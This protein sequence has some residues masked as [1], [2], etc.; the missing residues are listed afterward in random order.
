MKYKI[1][2]ALCQKICEVF[3]GK[4]LDIKQLIFHGLDR[5]NAM[6]GKRLGLQKRLCH[7]APHSKYVNCCNDSLALIFVYLMPQFKQ[8]RGVDATV[9]ALWKVFKYSSIKA[10]F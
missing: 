3:S 10:C 2:K 9:L 5:T 8:L 6:S 4:G 7:E 1:V